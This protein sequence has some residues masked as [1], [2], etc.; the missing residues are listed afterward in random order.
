M[1]KLFKEKRD[2]CGCTACVSICPTTAISMRSDE[3]GFKYPFVDEALCIDC[4]LC[5]KVCRFRHKA[6]EKDSQVMPLVY[7]AKHR[8][9]YVRMQSSSGGMFTA[10]SDHILNKNGAVYGAAYDEDIVCRHIR[11]IT[12]EE[13]AFCR[14]SKY[15]QSDIQGTFQLIKSDLNNGKNVL[16]TGTP[17]QVDGLNA[18]LGKGNNIENLLMVDFI[19]HGVPSP[20]VFADYIKYHEE[21]SKKKIVKYYNRCKDKGWGHTEK[22]VYEDGTF[23]YTSMF[24]QSWKYLFYANVMLRPSCYRCPYTQIKRCSDITIADFWGAKKTIPEF[25]D[26]K[27]ISLIL[28]NTEKA[29]EC[30]N[31]LHSDMDFLESNVESCI[32]MQGCLRRPTINDPKK[33]QQFWSDYYTKGISYV[34]KRYG[35][36]NTYGRIKRY[37]TDKDRWFAHLV[38]HIF[39][40]KKQLKKDRSI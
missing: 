7:A 28:V 13:S 6:N 15:V 32:S 17:C 5:L 21:K 29:R 9:E 34:L 18:F 39:Q 36:N 14:G 38:E 23:D 33:S 40:V 2:C 25:S 24:S 27:G 8:N 30:L 1:P 31:M 3:K 4:G 37:F 11:A 12:K 20:K 26:E 10:L 16:F 35:R 22:V 19:C